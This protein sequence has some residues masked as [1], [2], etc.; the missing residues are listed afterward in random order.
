MSNG[1][2]VKALKHLTIDGYIAKTGS[3]YSRT[4][5]PWVYDNEKVEKIINIRMHERERLKEYIS[6]DMCLMEFIT[7]ELDDPDPKKCNECSNCRGNY[8]ETSGSRANILKA[9]E[10]LNQDHQLIQPRRMWPYNIF[11][12]SKI[13]PEQHLQ[14]GRAMCLL[15]DAGWGQELR[16]S[17]Q[18]HTILSDDFLDELMG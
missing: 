11:P 15:E 14:Q 1:R 4:A 9:L 12:V 8:F 5:K 17:F 3:S 2:I 7:K 10:F 13:D 18:N 16:K 6:T